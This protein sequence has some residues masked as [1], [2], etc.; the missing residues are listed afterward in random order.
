MRYYVANK[1]Q[2][3]IITL[4][5]LLS[6]TGALGSL[7]EGE[8]RFEK[9][10]LVAFFVGW[11]IIPYLFYRLTSSRIRKKAPLLYRDCLF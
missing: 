9:L 6:A 8:F 1:F 11:G 3:T 4:G 10:L 5:I 2:L 7:F